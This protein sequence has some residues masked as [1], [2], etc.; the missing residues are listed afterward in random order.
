MS[1]SGSQIDELRGFNPL[2]FTAPFLDAIS[3]ELLELTTGSLTQVAV[4]VKAAHCNLRGSAHG[5]FVAAVADVALGLAVMRTDSSIESA[6]TVQMAVNY[7]GAAALGDVIVIDA[8]AGH[9]GRNLGFAS[10]TARSRGRVVAQGSGIFSLRRTPV[11]LDD[12]GAGSQ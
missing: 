2:G 3:A 9:V 5:G 11:A 4:E 10:M 6:V 7:T 12:A 8:E 1:A